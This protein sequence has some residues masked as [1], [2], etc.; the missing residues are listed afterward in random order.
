MP[1]YA[2]DSGG[3]GGTTYLAAD[4]DLEPKRPTRRADTVHFMR[5]GQSCPVGRFVFKLVPGAN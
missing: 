1:A 3:D 4:D 2:W 5:D